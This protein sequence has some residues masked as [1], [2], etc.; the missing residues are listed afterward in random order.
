MVL[1]K[2]I[3]KGDKKLNRSKVCFLKPM[4]IKKIKLIKTILTTEQQ[5]KAYEIQLT[6]CY[7]KYNYFEE[8]FIVAILSFF[9]LAKQLA[10]KAEEN[11]ASYC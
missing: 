7:S 11:F 3:R 5:Y 10:F 4:L 1:I 9:L 6:K 8:L 2:S